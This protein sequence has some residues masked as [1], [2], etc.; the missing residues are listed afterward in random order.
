MAGNS[1]SYPHPDGRRWVAWTASGYYM[2]SAGGDTLIGW[3]VNRGHARAADFFPVGHFGDQFYRPDIVL[4][5][6]ASLD[7]GAAKRAADAETGRTREV[8]DLT[9]RLPPVLQILNPLS[10]TSIVDPS[11]EIAYRVRSASGSSI[12]EIVVRSDGRFLGSTDAPALDGHGE[13]TGTLSLIVPERDSEILLFAK[14]KSGESEP[15]VIQ[16]TWT[17]PTSAVTSLRPKVYVLAVGIALYRDEKLLLNFPAKDAGDFVDALKKQ[18]GK[19]FSQVTP[20]LLRNSE[21][22]LSSI[23]DGLRWLQSVVKPEDI[24]IVFLSGHGYDDRQGFT[25]IC[26]RKRRWIC[27]P[28]RPCPIASCLRD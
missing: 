11:V 4:R 1:F 17:G 22:N 15:A 23:G 26:R 24:G 27:P 7:E 18:E 3:Q 19:A 28:A 12:D 21:A 20:K 8:A 13:A 2:A 5:T 14:G 6:L 25:I 9:T 16:F 10:G